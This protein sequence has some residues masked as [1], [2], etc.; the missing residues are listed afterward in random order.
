[1]PLSW[2]DMTRMPYAAFAINVSL[3]WWHID[4]LIIWSLS[5]VWEFEYVSVRPMDIFYFYQNKF[6]WLLT[7]RR[8]MP[9]HSLEGGNSLKLLFHRLG[10]ALCSCCKSTF[11]TGCPLVTKTIHDEQDKLLQFKHYWVK[12]HIYCT[13][14]N[15]HPQQPQ[16][17]RH[18][19]SIERAA[20]WF[21]LMHDVDICSKLDLH[22]VVTLPQNV[23]S[24]SCTI[25]KTELWTVTT[26][27]CSCSFP[28]IHRTRLV[29][30]HGGLWL[31]VRLVVRRNKL[32]LVTCNLLLPN[33]DLVKLV[34]NDKAFSK[35]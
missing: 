19:I 23:Y 26:T 2:N 8:T 35:C 5:K 20:V 15:S 16:S 17:I 31:V 6:S 27:A 1:M 9:R 12:V 10:S 3:F 29:C 25:G 14:V 4:I 22:A 34:F 24:S 18:N 30:H 7:V 28:V 32:K 11:I 13:V 33:P 21:I